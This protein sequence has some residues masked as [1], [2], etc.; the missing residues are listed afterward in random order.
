MQ[1]TLHENKFTIACFDDMSE[2]NPKLEENTIAVCVTL[3]LG[4]WRHG[5]GV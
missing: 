4:K 5:W 2:V 1:V 3:F